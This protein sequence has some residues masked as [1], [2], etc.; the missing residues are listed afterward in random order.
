MNLLIRDFSHYSWSLLIACIT[1]L[2][3]YKTLNR[4]VSNTF[5]V[6]GQNYFWVAHFT[7]QVLLNHGL[8]ES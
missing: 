4:T 3:N 8:V 2:V 6:F 1:V 7:L 5:S